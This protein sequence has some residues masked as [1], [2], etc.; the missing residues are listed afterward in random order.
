LRAQASAGHSLTMGYLFA[1]AF[2]FWLY[3][4][5]QLQSRRQFWLVGIGLWLGLIAAY[6]RA[7]WLVAATAGAV[8]MLASP[9]GRRGLVRTLFGLALLALPF[10]LTPWGARLIDTLPFIGTVDQ[11]NVDYRQELATLSWQLIK[12]NPFFG[13]PFAANYMEELRQG[14]GIIDIVNTYAWVSLFYGLVGCALFVGCFLYPM[15]RCVSLVWAGRGEEADAL[16]LGVALIA[17]MIGTLLMMA[18]ASFGSA[19]EQLSWILAGLCS[20][21]TAAMFARRAPVPGPGVAVVAPYARPA[22]RNAR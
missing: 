3:L 9:A 12:Q 13:N 21:Y 16:N 17:C 22:L 10:A 6:S 4:G 1:I 19:F 18:T 20:A 11:F 14:Q 2:G 15:L 5:G 8:Y 7:P